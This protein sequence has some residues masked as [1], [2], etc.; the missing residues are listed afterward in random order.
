MDFDLSPEQT[1]LKDGVERL[2]GSAYGSLEQRNAR[3]A[4]PLGFSEK[5]WAQFAEM[6]LTGIPFSEDEGGFGGG[7]VETLAVMEAL[8]RG[9]ALEPYFAT[10]VLGGS[11]VRLGGTEALKARIIPG[12]V[13]GTTRLAL[14]V[15]EKQ[16]RYDLFDVAT[17]ARSDGDGFLIDGAKSVVVNGDS[18]DRLVVSARTDGARRDREG[19]SL[20]LVPADAPG[21]TIHG[22]P[23]QDGGRAAEISLAQVRVGAD[24][25]IGQAGN[26]LPVLERVAEFAIAAL[27]AEA[28]GIMAAL[29]QMTMDYLKTRQQ[30]GG[31]IAQFQVLQH[32]AVDM[33]IALEQA[34]SMAFY[35]AM[36]VEHADAAERAAALSAVKVQ[37]NRS[38]RL[39]GQEAV[40]LHGGIGMTMEYL[41]AHY[42]K[43]LTMIES[44]FGDTPHHLRH[45]GDA[46]GLEKWANRQ[47]LQGQ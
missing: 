29:H 30:F 7:P 42:F 8:G 24:A 46:G 27:A 45:V 21:V 10:V 15:T 39:V 38:C 44:L 41:G 25:L 35:A 19:I 1:Q 31:P 40:Q 43:R 47:S 5:V 37:I 9:L 26:G 33:F 11:A 2:I 12:I 14:A 16:S 36:M 28:V 4:G 13:E 34:R 6:G 22:Y 18:A 3:A 32:R 23:T 17:T 20:L